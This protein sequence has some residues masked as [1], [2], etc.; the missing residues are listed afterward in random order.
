MRPRADAV[1][2]RKPSHRAGFVAIVGRTNVGKSTLLNQLLG[3]KVAIV[4]DLPQTTRHRIL[5]VRTLPHAQIAFLDTPGIHRPR[6]RMNRLMVSAALQA[7]GQVD[8]VLFMLDA[9]QGIGPGDRYVAR[10]LREIPAGRPVVVVLNKVDR[11][12]KPGLLPMIEAISRDWSF[13]EIVPLSALSGENC[14]RLLEVVVRLLPE[15]DPLYPPDALTDQPERRLVTELIREKILAATRQELP[16]ETAVMIDAWRAREDGLVEI[17]ATIYCERD[18]QKAIIV[19]R[20]GGL[21]KKVGT[22]ARLEIERVLGARVM[23]RLW[24]KVRRGWRENESILRQLGIGG[25]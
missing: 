6:H 2:V 22:G 15:G 3:E 10:L 14:D 4:S 13:G 1:E 8:V 23:L 25:D 5:G 24:V 18:S 7:L 11:V 20:G 19:G 21:L 17:A 9:S 12:L 16:H